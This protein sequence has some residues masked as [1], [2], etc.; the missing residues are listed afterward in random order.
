MSLNLTSPKVIQALLAERGFSPNH[1]L[2]QNFLIDQNI[3][4][5]IINAAEVTQDDRV[6]EVGPGLGTLTQELLA[7]AGHVTAVEKDTGIFNI[8]RDRWG[9][10][11]NLTLIQG[12]ALELDHA[13]LQY[14][15][16]ISNLPYAV[17]TRVV[18]DAAAQEH[19]PSR[20]VMLVQKE[21]AERFAARPSTSDIGPISIWLQQ[22]YTVD[23]IKSVKGTCFWPKPDVT[24]A[25]VRLRR[26]D[27]HPLTF[28]QRK[29]LWDITRIA[30]SQRRKQMAT[31]FK[32]AQSPYTAP[33]DDIRR[34]LKECGASET[35]RAEELSLEQWI[36]LIFDF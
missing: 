6:L 2:G 33:P 10:L 18:V 26:N 28:E 5:I 11:P 30:F 17:G 32:G 16:L 19:P 8:L 1:S 20:M 15:C 21:V 3:L 4:D 24:S 7:R 22:L 9:T 29:R 34:R 25:V 36:Q 31:L 27:K 23:I 14:T 13:A 35:A 12:D